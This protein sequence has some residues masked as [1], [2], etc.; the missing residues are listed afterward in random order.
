MTRYVHIYP[1]E[2]HH[3]LRSGACDCIP[4]VIHE[5]G[6]TLVFHR[7]GPMSDIV[8]AAAAAGADAEA[9]EDMGWAVRVIETSDA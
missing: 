1:T 3:T 9:L 7:D 8:K 6:N 2:G 5:Q 4:D